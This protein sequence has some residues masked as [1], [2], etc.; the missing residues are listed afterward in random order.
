M[1]T[2][3]S[4]SAGRRALV[5]ALVFGL[6][7]AFDTGDSASAGPPPAEASATDL[8]DVI[9]FVERRASGGGDESDLDAALESILREADEGGPAG[10]A[11]PDS[12]TA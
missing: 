4:D 11:G 3:S 8:D 5:V 2:T 7:A 10:G 9:G 12:P 1:S 6:R